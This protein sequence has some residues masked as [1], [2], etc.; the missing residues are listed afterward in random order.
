MARSSSIV[1]LAASLIPGGAIQLLAQDTA[2]PATAELRPAAS[3]REV[4]P[5]VRL[6]L[7]RRTVEFDGVV[8]ISLTDPRAPRVYLELIA[9]V[10]DSKEHESLVMTDARPSHIHAALLAVGLNPGKPA[11]WSQKDGQVISNAPTGDKVRVELV[12][13]GDL[14]AERVWTPDQ[15]IRSAKSEAPW[16]GDGMIARGHWVF[17]GSMTINRAG[18]EGGADVYKADEEGTVIGLASFGTEIIAWTGVL[19]PDSQTDEPEWIADARHVP[20]VDTP[21]TVRIIAE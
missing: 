4:F 15:W 6:D 3:A 17:A 5:H 7:A 19:S 16:P 21:V 14:G 2:P 8:P 9:C 13:R 18:G 12:T 1:A 11:T 10:R 20:P